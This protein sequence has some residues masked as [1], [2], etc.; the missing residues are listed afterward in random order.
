M[1]PQSFAEAGAQQGESH[2]LIVIIAVVVVVGGATQLSR[3]FPPTSDPVQP[4][5]D[6]PE[7]GAGEVGGS[8]AQEDSLATG[9]QPARW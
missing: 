2:A 9:P 5:E 7:G 6:H 4:G 8:F 1:G 3:L